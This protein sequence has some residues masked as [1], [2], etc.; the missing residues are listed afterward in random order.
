V[1][2]DENLLAEVTGLVEWPVALRGGFDES[3]LL[4]PRQAL[5]SSM[6]E[7]QKY[8]HIESPDGDLLPSFITISNIESKRPES[9]IYGNEKV[10]RPRLADAAFFFDT[11]K[12][13]TLA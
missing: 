8:F 7:H 4:V 1:I 11:D 5:I 2:V 9:V 13:T 10:I 12:E 3:F 6:R